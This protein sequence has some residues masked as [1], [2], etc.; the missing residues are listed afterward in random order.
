MTKKWISSFILLPSSKIKFFTKLFCSFK[1]M[2]TLF[3]QFPF[4][5]TQSR[6]KNVLRKN[7]ITVLNAKKSKN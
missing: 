5:I 2:Q 6:K 4:E 1:R 3:R 7:L